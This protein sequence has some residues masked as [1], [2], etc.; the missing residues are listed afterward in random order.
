MRELRGADLC[1]LLD[2]QRKYWRERFRWDFTVS[3]QAIINFLDNR[4]L[5]GFALVRNGLPVGY[6]YFVVEGSKALV[7]DIFTSYQRSDPTFE[8]ALLIRTLETA[9]AYPG[10][11]RVEGQLLGLNFEL[12]AETIFHHPLQ[13]FPRWFMMLEQLRPANSGLPVSG[14]RHERRNDTTG[15]RP[16]ELDPRKHDQLPDQQPYDQVGRRN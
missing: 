13:I 12:R 4:T 1:P 14:R 16:E 8:K 6:C 7:G 9:A 11:N 15:A 10:V 5:H 3:A 2:Q